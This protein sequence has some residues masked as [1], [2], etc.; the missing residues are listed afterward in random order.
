MA[1]RPV[2]LKLESYNLQLYNK[3]C[4]MLDIWLFPEQLLLQTMFELLHRPEQSDFNGQSMEGKMKI[5][6]EKPVLNNFKA[7]GWQK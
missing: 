5:R 2:S 3:N 7:Y 1:K 4:H 6:L